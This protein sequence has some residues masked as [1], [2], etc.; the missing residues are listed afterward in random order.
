MVKFGLMVSSAPIEQMERHAVL[1]ERSGFDSLWVADHLAYLDY[2]DFCP[3]AWCVLSALAGVTKRDTLGTSVTDPYRRH[4]AVLAQTV[5]TLDQISEGRA[6]LGLGAGEAM[7]VDPFG[8]ARDR[9][10]S[11]MKE[12]IEILR[13]L[14]TREIID[15]EGKSFNLSEAFIQVPPVQKPYPPI[16][17]AANS[18]TTRKLVGL[19]GDGW[20]AEMMSPERYNA[21]IKEVEFAAK[22][23]GR[24]MEDIDVTY[25]V[26]TA[27]SEDYDEARK[28]ALFYAKKKFL[29]WPKQIQQYGY[30][31]TDEFDWNFLKVK[32]DTAKKLDEHVPEVPDKPAEEIT[33]F[34]TPEDCIDKIERYIRSGVTHFMF[35]LHSPYVETCRLM[36][37]KIIP[38]FKESEK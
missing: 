36:Q 16:Y 4:P 34:G 14:W 12:T 22:N 27:V 5:A 7:N 18:P 31:I 19:Y 24:K 3:E 25:A 38:Y 30:S 33:I 37:T 11:R 15:Y 1:A 35:Y 20:L 6:I 32:K 8:I 9:R 17:I 26:N 10:I 29:W 13:K 2:E 23:T 21:D 28:K